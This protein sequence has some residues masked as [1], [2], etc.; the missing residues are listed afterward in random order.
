MQPEL[1]FVGGPHDGRKESGDYGD[2]AIQT[3]R[4]LQVLLDGLYLYESNGPVDGVETHI[5]LSYRGRDIVPNY[6]DDR[7]C[8]VAW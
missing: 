1:D 4:V 2:D 7:Y 6:D 3:D 5:G 8:V